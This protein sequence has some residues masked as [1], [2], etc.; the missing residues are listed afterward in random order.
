VQYPSYFSAVFT[1]AG[2]S[3]AEK[4]FITYNNVAV[5]DL[6]LTNTG[7]APLTATLTAASPIATTA[8]A[9]GS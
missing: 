1:R 8:S 4:K 7:D 2:L 9:D 5:T 3:V 6:T